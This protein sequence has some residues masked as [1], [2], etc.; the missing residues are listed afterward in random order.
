MFIATSPPSYYKYIYSSGE[1]KCFKC[2]ET[3]KYSKEELL[4]ILEK[5]NYGVEHDTLKEGFIFDFYWQDSTGNFIDSHPYYKI[6]TIVIEGD[7][8]TDLQFALQEMSEDKTK[9]WINGM[10][11]SK[12]ISDD[13]VEKKLRKYYGRLIKKHIQ[14]T[15]RNSQ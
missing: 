1:L 12:E 4:N 10:N 6:H 5:N 7:T 3:V 14:E 13:E 11:I 2:T 15:I 8:I 9:I